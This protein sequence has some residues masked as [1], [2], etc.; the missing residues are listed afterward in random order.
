MLFILLF[1]IQGIPNS[2]AD[3]YFNPALI[4]R[5]GSASDEI[6]L[7]VF[8]EG[9]QIPGI[10]RVDIFVNQNYQETRDVTFFSVNEHNGKMT[11]KPCLSVNALAKYGIKT[12]LF[13]GLL[14]APDKQCADLSVIPDSAVQ[15][16]FHK[17][18]LILS[19]PQSV[20]DNRVRGYVPPELWDEGI[21]AALLNYS[22]TA[23]HSRE[24]N[25]TDTNSDNYYLNLRPGINI[26][27]WRFRNYTTWNY[28]RDKSQSQ[29]S[30]NKSLETVYTYAQR[31]IP[32]I[33]SS[34]TLGDSNTPADI[35]DSTPFRGIQLTSDDDMLPESVRGYA[36][37]VR[38]I[39]RSNA[40]VI[41]RQNGY[42]IYQSYVPPGAFEINDMYPTGGSGDLNVTIQEADGSEQHLVVPFASLPIL[43][44]EGRLKYNLTG[45]QYRSY[46]R[47]V[48]KQL[49]MMSTAIYGLPYG[50]TL[51]GGGQ[52]AD[53]YQSL[54]IGVG[55]NIGELGAISADVSQA[56][57]E[58]DK[59]NRQNGQSWRIRYSKNVAETGTNFTIAGYRYSTGGYYNLQEVLE[60]YRPISSYSFLPGR[61]KNR[62][63]VSLNQNLLQEMGS[64]SLSFLDEDY[65]N[66]SRRMQSVGLGYNNSWEGISYGLNYSYN[67]NRQG[68]G[69][70]RGSYDGEQIFAFN[71]S[72]PLDNWLPGTSASYSLNTSKKGDT[73]HMA[74]LSGTALAGNNLSWSI[75]QGYSSAEQGYSGDLNMDWRATYGEVTAGYG[76]DKHQRRVNYGLKGGVIVHA[77]GITLGQPLGETS[78]LVKA[79]GTG[80][81]N[82]NNQAG[83][84]TDWRGYAIVPFV[85]PYRKN[86]IQINPETLPEN[87]ELQ[88]TNQTVAPTRGAVVRATFNA[89]IG[90]RV[91]M[92]LTRS[93][94]QPVPF[95]ATV[96]AGSVKKQPFI[97][98]NAGQVYLTGMEDSGVLY[99]EWAKD[100]NGHCRVHYRLPELST[101]TGIKIT[102][103][104]CE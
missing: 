90:Q 48:D 64:I 8:E 44:R 61:R 86:T 55:K 47:G 15:F 43:Q 25:G 19:V 59:Q 58:P 54:S 3:G 38:G 49:F 98:G 95:G 37:V 10:Y 83:V 103:E 6:D 56:R 12:P 65:W 66:S 26:G 28:S 91:L 94:G 52:F 31:D 99:V 71:I 41:I 77:N 21:S 63:E 81:A 102:R 101:A 88:L 76:Y 36:P 5:T 72:I 92:T 100:S 39:A 35:F 85:S 50:Y 70:N 74:G 80:G 53:K 1:F 68:S 51:Y 62:T 42:I 9:G 24:R 33:K 67:H 87:A 104:I 46:D 79:P 23:G 96:T 40:Q 27:A 7:S 17:Q 75:Q 93:D 89:D 14:S 29:N 11:L 2:S 84:T 4:E 45:G 32:A 18:Q 60:T 57:S 82:I 22:F 73:T 34:L 97:T 69:K 30:A 78:A 13:P 20:M 16:L